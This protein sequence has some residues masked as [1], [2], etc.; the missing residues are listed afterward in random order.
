MLLL[1]LIRWGSV[2]REA[3]V[4]VV[5]DNTA[6]LGAAANLRGRGALTAISRELAWRK[7][8]HQWRFAVGHLPSEANTVADTLSRL[9]APDGADSKQ[10]PEELRGVREVQPPTFQETFTLDALEL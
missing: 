4:A 8:R 6:S 1:T 7:V 5:G 9:S 3:G 10:F 2:T